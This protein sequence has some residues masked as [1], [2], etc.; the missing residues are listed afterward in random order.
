MF[1]CS[2]S[3]EIQTAGRIGKKFGTEVVLDGGK[4]LGG[5]QPGTPIPPGT[6]CVK[7]VWGAS[8]ASGVHFGENFIEQKLQGTPNLVRFVIFL[9]PKS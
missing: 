3:I 4:V 2:F 7:G 1:V 8:G 5:F 9:D 6:G